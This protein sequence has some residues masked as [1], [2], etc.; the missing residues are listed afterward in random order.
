MHKNHVWGLLSVRKTPQGTHF[1]QKLT[2]RDTH[3]SINFEE[4]PEHVELGLT[5]EGSGMQCKVKIAK[6]PKQLD[7]SEAR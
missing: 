3:F 2:F 7:F 1:Q 6:I 5:F 4:V